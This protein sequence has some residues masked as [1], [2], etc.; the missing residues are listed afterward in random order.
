MKHQS[1]GFLIFD[2]KSESEEFVPI[3]TSRP[4]KYEEIDVTGYT[5]SEVQQLMKDW[6]TKNSEPHALLVLKLTGKLLSGRSGEINQKE[7]RDI[8][9]DKGCLAISVMNSIEDPVR[10]ATDIKSTMN[11]ESFFRKWFNK[12]EGGKAIKYFDKFREFGDNYSDEIKDRIV[13]ELS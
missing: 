1:K 9:A 5:S 12:D 7:C 13:E 3:P 6:V 11:V 10:T 8:A 2:T 4:M